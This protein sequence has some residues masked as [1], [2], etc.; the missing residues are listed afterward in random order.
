MNPVIKI[1]QKQKALSIIMNGSLG[2]MLMD[3]ETTCLKTW[4]L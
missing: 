4:G 2:F 3:N 1:A